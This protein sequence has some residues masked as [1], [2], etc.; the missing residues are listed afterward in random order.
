MA[1]YKN[2][3]LGVKFDV[4]DKITVRQQLVYRGKVFRNLNK[5]DFFIVAWDGAASLIEKWECDLIP[6]I[7]AFDIDKTT[8]PRQSLILFWAGDT[9]AGHMLELENIPKN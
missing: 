9:V 3:K 8:D 6:D 4:P 7:A 1:T 2:E 5:D